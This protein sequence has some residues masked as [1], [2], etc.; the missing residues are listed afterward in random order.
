MG[1]YRSLRR[2]RVNKEPLEEFAI[3]F[4]VP[5]DDS[6]AG[7]RAKGIEIGHKLDVVTQIRGIS[8][9]KHLGV[10]TRIEPGIIE[11]Q[12]QGRMYQGEMWPAD[13]RFQLGIRERDIYNI[14]Y[15]TSDWKR[16]K[17]FEATISEIRPIYQASQVEQ[18]AIH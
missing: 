5:W 4:K 16:V 10:V 18:E 8:C 14:G 15:V 13:E 12:G 11:V 2:K 17:A 7:L 9:P 3:A 6:Q 1:I